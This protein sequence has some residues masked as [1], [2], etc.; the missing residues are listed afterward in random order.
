MFQDQI[1]LNL[2]LVMV[3]VGQEQNMEIIVE[4]STTSG[5]KLVRTDTKEVLLIIIMGPELSI[6]ELLELF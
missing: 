4:S 6:Q 1:H 5:T 2:I 3:G